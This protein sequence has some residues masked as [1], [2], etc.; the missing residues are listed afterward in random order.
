MKTNFR[1]F[2]SY[3]IEGT[4]KWLQTKKAQGYELVSINPLFRIFHF[5]KT[6]PAEKNIKILYKTPQLPETLLEEETITKEEIDSLVENGRIV[7]HDEF[8]E[9]NIPDELKNNTEDKEEKASKKK[10]NEKNNET[11]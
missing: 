5:I 4:E 7:K 1:P 3:R 11:E 9:D 8:K 2:W 10:T 6:S